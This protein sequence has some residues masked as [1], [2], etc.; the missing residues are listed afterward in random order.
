MTLKP[1]SVKITQVEAH[2]LVGRV[3]ADGRVEPAAD[4]REGHAEVEA[5][6]GEEDLAPLKE[7]AAAD[8]VAVARSWAVLLAPL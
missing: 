2:A 1:A 3:Q 4:L 8:D 7:E 5:I 6:L